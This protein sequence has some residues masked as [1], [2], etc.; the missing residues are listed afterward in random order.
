MA[1]VTW[2][3]LAVLHRYTLV[4][5]PSH[6]VEPTGVTGTRESSSGNVVVQDL[7][8]GCTYGFT[9]KTVNAAGVESNWA[10][11]VDVLMA[12]RPAKPEAVR[13]EAGPSYPTS[14]WIYFRAL[15]DGG[16]NITSYVVA[17]SR[18]TS[19]AVEEGRQTVAS[20]SLTWDDD[21]LARVELADLDEYVGVL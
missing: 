9:A 12:A 8:T 20:T 21:G 4:S 2:F 10:T 14:M 15:G 11:T 16:N 7:T 19:F 3:R 17:W 6:V 13:G 1:S 5:C 18:T